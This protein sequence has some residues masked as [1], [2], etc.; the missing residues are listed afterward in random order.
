MQ[1]S[2][3][4]ITHFRK[5]MILYRVLHFFKRLFFKFSVALR[6][7]WLLFPSVTFVAA[8]LFCFWIL[9][10]GKD[11]LITTLELGW[12]RGIILLALL[13]YSLVTWYSSRV[14]A[15]RRPQIYV[16][17][18]LLGYHGPR[19]L[20]FSV[21][22]ILLLGLLQIQPLADQHFVFRITLNQAWCLLLASLLIYYP[23]L[24]LISSN[25]RDN[26]LVIKTPNNSPKSYEDENLEK[27]RF[28][29]T[30]TIVG[31]VVIFIIGVNFINNNTQGWLFWW[32]VFVLQLLYIFIIIIRRGRL[33]GDNAEPEMPLHHKTF[34]KWRIYEA[35]HGNNIGNDLWRKLLYHSNISNK[36]VWFF[37]IYNFISAISVIVYAIVIYKY[38]FAVKFGTLGTLFLGFGVLV[39]IFSFIS[40]FSLIYRTNFH[41]IILIVVLILGGK[42]EPHN[43]SLVNNS[44]ADYST[45]HSKR[46]QLKQFLYNWVSNR[47]NEMDS[48]KGEYPLFFVLADG[49]A[50][51]SGYWTATV[52]SSLQDT[53]KGIFS[54]HLFCLSGASGGSVGNGTFM[55]LLKNQ[56][57]L[58][59]MQ[60]TT[61]KSGAGSFLK[62]DF[63]S[64]TIARMLGPD[65]IRP[66]AGF[67]PIT[68]MG[69]RA[70][71]LEHAI[72]NAGNDGKTF[73]HRKFATPFSD[74]IPGTN[75]VN[76][77][78]A[79]CINCTRM[80]DGRP[81][82]LSNINVKAD[83][84]IFGKRIDILNDLDSGKDIILST[85]VV[86]GAR[87]PYVSPA[88]RI[89]NSYYV[90][91]GYFDNSG[92]GF[93]L[94]MIT[95]LKKLQ[96][97]PEFEKAFPG[98]K[99]KL[100]YNIL[101][102]Q[103]SEPSNGK[104]P[105][106]I[107]P[108]MNDLA[109]PIQTLVGAYGTQTS[110]NDWRLE[111]Y[112]GANRYL[113]V[114]LHTDKEKGLEFPMN[115]AISNFYIKKMNSQLNNSDMK[116]VYKIFYANGMMK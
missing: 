105:E 87:F 73:L 40:F 43:V 93:V 68:T 86:L 52:L 101:H 24:Y 66:M 28:K 106:K 78:P 16:D 50:S 33:P 29:I 108:L 75:G 21:Y 83:S 63:L 13:F 114:N 81:S 100:T 1:N 84:A 41:V 94:E 42:F 57:E 103:N 11:V 38:N 6:L 85:A 116:K 102:V 55:A 112:I 92:S 113:K 64:Y 104:Q 18:K 4:K 77:L 67:I 89:K 96:N 80:Q 111:K 74:L 26:K 46:P 49:G 76:D 7:V 20:G 36:E 23:V 9:S 65:F 115:W 95:E 69:D 51:R 22:T 27:R 8:T 19:V 58:K 25:I 39:G 72:E 3:K 62:S 14:I 82:V 59:K 97:D 109:A 31:A 44:T 10:Q 60:D 2:V 107:H 48:C 53:T 5:Y 91:G 30:Y 12:T 88:G 35:A 61:F 79:F 45:A 90:D 71:A 17:S 34:Q 70:E 32:S 47:K 54:K 56:Q 37:K 15:Y 99:D 110:V 98:V